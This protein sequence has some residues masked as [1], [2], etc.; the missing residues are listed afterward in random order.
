V[1]IHSIP[2]FPLL[3]SKPHHNLNFIFKG[4]FITMSNLTL[5]IFLLIFLS[6]HSAL[7]SLK[8]RGSSIVTLKKSVCAFLIGSLTLMDPSQAVSTEYKQ[9]S[10]ERYHTKLMYPS[11]WVQKKAELSG[12][13]LLD[14]FVDPT[15]ADTSASV[16]ITPIPGDFTR[17]TSFG[18]LQSYLLPKGDGVTLISD[19]TKGNA[20]TV[21][22]VISEPDAPT[23]HIKTIFGL[24]PQESV[25]GLTIQTKESKFEELKK[26]FEEVSTSF[27]F[28]SDYKQ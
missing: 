7:A 16:A 12:S 4:K 26:T 15:D 20:Y 13:R 2:Y 1:E 24:R 27:S 25:V 19:S 22:Y 9:F 10:N 14:A 11:S 8:T 6:V 21:E 18:D 28:D 5:K 3:N 17:L 23:R